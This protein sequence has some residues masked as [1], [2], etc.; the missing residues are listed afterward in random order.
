MEHRELIEVLS[1]RL[2]TRAELGDLGDLTITFRANRNGGAHVPDCKSVSA[3]AVYDEHVGAAGDDVRLSRIRSGLDDTLKV[4]TTIRE[5]GAL[6]TSG[7]TRFYPIHWHDPDRSP[8][9]DLGRALLTTRV[10]VTETAVTVRTR[11]DEDTE[12]HR[13]AAN[14]GPAGRAGRATAAGTGDHGRTGDARRPRPTGR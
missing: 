10:E 4:L 8:F 2:L 7:L 11:I 3:K 13:G 14:P 5:R 6:E 1:A 12:L 9:S